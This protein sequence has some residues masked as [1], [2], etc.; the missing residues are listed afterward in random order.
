MAE[1][2][3]R[4]HEAALSANTSTGMI[5]ANQDAKSPRSIHGWKVS[6]QFQRNGPILTPLQWATAYGSMLSTTFLFALDNTIVC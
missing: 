6:S 2:K 1:Q 3:E 5:S 4:H